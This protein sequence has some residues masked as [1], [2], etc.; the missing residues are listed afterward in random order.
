M[1]RYDDTYSLHIPHSFQ[2]DQEGAIIGFAAK[3]EPSEKAK[4]IRFTRM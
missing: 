1:A 3:L 2:T 4:E